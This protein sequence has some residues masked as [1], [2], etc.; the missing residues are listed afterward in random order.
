MMPDTYPWDNLKPPQAASSYTR[1]LIDEHSLWDVFWAV[2]IND[3]VGLMLDCGSLDRPSM[4]A[5]ELRELEVRFLSREG[6]DLQIL[7]MLRDDNF[8][9]VFFEFCKGLH[10]HIGAESS[11][12]NAAVEAINYTWSWYRFLN[13]KRPEELS[14]EAQRGLIGELVFLRDYLV[15]RYSWEDA[16]NFWSGPFG[17]PKD[18]SWGEFAVEA[19]THLNDACPF[20]KIS[21]EFQLDAEDISILWLFVLGFQRDSEDGEDSKTLTDVVSDIVSDL[22]SSA[23]KTLEG[24]YHH[25][26][27]Y[28]YS[29]KHNYDKY[30][31]RWNNPRLFRVK[32][33][34]PAIQSAGLLQGV[35]KVS[36]QISLPACEPFKTEFFELE[37]EMLNER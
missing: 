13:G 18:F 11:I 9:S 1:L 26:L 33:D 19:K 16:I 21:S 24:F 35:S 4:E 30:H 37:S 6:D 17:N 29:P 20:I 8:K 14:P 34:F 31:W 36:Y 27:A 3:D 25:L 32:K 12:E 2:D 28:G 22:S 10:E 5:P 7:F 23:P 15:P